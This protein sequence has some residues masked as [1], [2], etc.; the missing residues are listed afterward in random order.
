MLASFLELKKVFWEVNVDMFP[1]LAENRVPYEST[2]NT[3]Q[4]EV[5][6]PSKTMKKVS[7]SK[8]T[9]YE[10]EAKTTNLFYMDFQ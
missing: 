9:M 2:V 8:K 7:K 10:S 3:G 6:A 4:I 1:D 5:R